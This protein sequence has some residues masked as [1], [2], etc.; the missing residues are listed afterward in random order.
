MRHT[1]THTRADK[2]KQNKKKTRKNAL[3]RS[4]NQR[5]LTPGDDTIEYQTGPMGTRMGFRLSRR[6]QTAAERDGGI[7]Q[8]YRG[9]DSK[10]KEKHF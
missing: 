7:A 4:S 10:S 1:H 3:A 2:Q 8:M 9:A 6:E 5:G